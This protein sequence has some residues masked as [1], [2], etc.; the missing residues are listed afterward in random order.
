MLKN[1]DELTDQ[2]DE[3]TK[4]LKQIGEPGAV[5]RTARL[6]LEFIKDR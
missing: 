4:V 5:E 3:L 2:K 1:P 6:V